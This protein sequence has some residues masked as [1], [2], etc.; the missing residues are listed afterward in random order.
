MVPV[1]SKRLEHIENVKCILSKAY[2]MFGSK[3]NTGALRR[4]FVFTTGLHWASHIWYM[5][6]AWRSVTGTM[7]YLC[8]S[9][10]DRQ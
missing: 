5:T 3:R 4:A 9:S 10:P 7:G 2:T 6:F 1:T 8:T